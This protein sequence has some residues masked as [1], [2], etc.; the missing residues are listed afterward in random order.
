MPYRLSDQDILS[1]ALMSV[2]HMTEIYNDTASQ[3]DDPQLAR[4]LCEMISEEH[5]ARIK[6]FEVMRQRGWYTTQPIDQQQLRQAQQKLTQMSQTMQQG[7]GV[8][9]TQQQTNEWRQPAAGPWQAS[10]GV[11]WQQST[12]GQTGAWQTTTQWPTTSS[13]IRPTQ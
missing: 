10:T 4:E 13:G 1:S 8:Q 5:S 11:N 3:T 9:Q 2:K 6:M 12:A 7:R